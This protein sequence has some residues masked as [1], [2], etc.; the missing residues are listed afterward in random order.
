MLYFKRMKT[1]ICAFILILVSAPSISFADIYKYVDKNGVVHFTNIPKGRQYN[2][3]LTDKST[4][5]INSAT[6]KKPA[7]KPST[8]SHLIDNMSKK[9]DLEPSL[10]KAVIKV[11]SD[12]DSRAVSRKGAQGLMQLMPSTAKNM[13]VK[14]PYNPEDNI[15]GGAKYLRLLLDKFDGDLSL[16]LAAYNAGPGRIEEHG[17]I[18]PITETRKYVDRVLSLYNG[19]GYSIPAAPIYKIKIRNGTILYTNTTSQYE[20]NKIS[21]F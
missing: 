16:A 14:N 10:I 8:Y 15:N 18:P 19:E 4:I 1:V 13:N 17:G 5:P 21:R 9:Y 3:I 6:R 2:R 12:W 20:G 7:N 11:E